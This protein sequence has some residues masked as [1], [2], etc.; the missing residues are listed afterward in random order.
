MFTGLVEEIGTCLSLR[1][2]ED[3]GELDVAAPGLGAHIKVGESI[4]VNG[5]CLTVSE[6][7]GERLHFDLLGETLRRTNLGP[8]KAGS[9]V[10]L[11][12]ALP[13]DGRI[14]GHFVQG[15]VD[16]TAAMRS[17]ENQSPDL[18]LEFEL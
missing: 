9:A 8:L 11:E 12:R 6:Q 10:N 2:H 13:A 16:C 14:G 1:P 3:A 7:N 5:C 17:R 18:K 4:A 15:H